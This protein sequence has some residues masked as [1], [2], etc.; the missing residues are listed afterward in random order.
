M[1]GTPPEPPPVG[2]KKFVSKISTVYVLEVAE[3][4]ATVVVDHA[5]AVAFVS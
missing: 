2:I 1:R 4:V 3:V 5:V